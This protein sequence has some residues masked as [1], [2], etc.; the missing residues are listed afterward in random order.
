M[1]EKLIRS[2]LKKQIQDREKKLKLKP[3]E[4]TTFRKAKLDEQLK[5]II[6]KLIE[7]LKE[8]LKAIKKG[9]PKEILAEIADFM[10][11]LST[12][13]TLPEFDPRAISPIQSLKR[14]ERGGF[15]T[16]TIASFQKK[17][18]WPNTKKKAK[19]KKAVRRKK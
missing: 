10:E 8:V 12:A 9:D 6:Q 15:E 3:S 11:A 4:R 13:Q 19:A 17:P 5:I 16:F 14:F 2:K 1:I 18:E 7:E